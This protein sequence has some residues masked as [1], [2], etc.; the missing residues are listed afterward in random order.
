MAQAIGD[1]AQLG[2]DDVV[3]GLAA[4]EETGWAQHVDGEDVWQQDASLC[5]DI[6]RIADAMIC[7]VV[8]AEQE[9]Q[10]VDDFAIPLRNVGRR[11]AV[12]GASQPE[13]LEENAAASGIKLDAATLAAID[14]AVQGVV[15]YGR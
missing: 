6:R 12:V 4:V 8:E 1:E 11:I 2:V 13:Q 3:G 14:A 10:R 9:L 5:G 7:R 15:A